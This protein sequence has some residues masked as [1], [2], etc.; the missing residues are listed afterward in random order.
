[1]KKHEDTIILDRNPKIFELV[2]N[3]LRNSGRKPKIQDEETMMLFEEEI[4]Y[5]NLNIQKNEL[6]E[7]LNQ[8]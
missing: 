1:M 4:D 6:N 2:L 3:Y 8:V 5:W 7:E